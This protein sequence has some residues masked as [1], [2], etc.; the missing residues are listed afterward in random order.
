MGGEPAQG[1]ALAQRLAHEADVEQREVTQPA[2]D[3]LGGERGGGRGEIAL[4]DEGDGEAAQREV[5]GGARSR[6]PAADDDDVVLAVDQRAGCRHV[7]NSR[8]DGSTASGPIS[9]MRASPAR[10]MP[11]RTRTVVRPWR[12]PIAM[13]VSR[14]SPTI[15][16]SSALTPRRARA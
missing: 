4:V 8:T 7:I 16:Q 15:T 10:V 3:Q 5:A 11:E 14:R 2:V 13:S 9:A 12:R 1:L 6:H